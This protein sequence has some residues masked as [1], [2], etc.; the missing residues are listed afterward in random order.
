MPGNQNEQR[1]RSKGIVAYKGRQCGRQSLEHS[2]L[3]DGYLYGMI[4]YKKFSD[5][6]LKCVEL[7]TGKVNWEQPG[8]GAGNV[9][10]A[11]DDLIALSD[12]G[13]VVLLQAN[14]EGCRKK[15]E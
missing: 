5:G 2:G 10:L 11:G 14:P 3:Q 7:K 6:P 9:I 13:E 12:K 4:S 8:F 1:F 15:V